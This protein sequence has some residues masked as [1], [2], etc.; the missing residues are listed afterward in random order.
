M[1]ELFKKIQQAGALGVRVVIGKEEGESLVV[2]IRQEDLPEDI[3]AAGHELADLLGLRREAA[4]YTVAYGETARNDRELAIQTRSMM[5]IMVELAGQ[6]NV[7]DSHIVEGR[8]VAA[9]PVGN[10]EST[11]VHDLERLIDIKVSKDQP[12]EGFVAVQYKN[13]WFWLDDRDFKSKRTFAY[14]MIL[15][16]LTETGGRE[17]L[18]LITIPAG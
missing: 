18:P 9:R 4:E 14:L 2:V 5:A 8:T 15:F 10:L 1:V 3:I 7:P 6:V 17:A 16:S 11:N 12:D 13:Y